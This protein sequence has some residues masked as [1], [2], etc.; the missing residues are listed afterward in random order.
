MTSKL[1]L[2]AV[3]AL[4]TGGCS[5][6]GDGDTGNPYRDP[7]AGSPGSAYPA[8]VNPP[9]FNGTVTYDAMTSGKVGGD[10]VLAP[11]QPMPVK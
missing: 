9:A 10:A 7:Y 6:F 5:Y 1:M 2:A 4:M 11:P 3:A 8:D